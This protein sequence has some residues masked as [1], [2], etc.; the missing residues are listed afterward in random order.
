[1]EYIF[2][3]AS[4]VFV[5]GF[6]MIYSGIMNS[7]MAGNMEREEVQKL[8]TKFFI[9]IAV[10]E[11]PIIVAIVLAIMYMEQQAQNVNIT[12]PIV[13]IIFITVIGLIRVL[14]LT[15]DAKASVDDAGLKNTVQTFFF[16]GMALLIAIPLICVVFLI[17]LSG[18]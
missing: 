1:M 6:L 3:G 11:G 14:M 18:V 12:L 7:I 13:L 17:T 5:F 16:L 9:R 4:A 2:V 10:M 15:R 8:Q